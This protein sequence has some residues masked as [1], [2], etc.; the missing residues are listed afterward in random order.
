MFLEF[1]DD[2]LPWPFTKAG[3]EEVALV[4]PEAGGTRII[5][6]NL[7]YPSV[8][9]LCYALRNKDVWPEG[10]TW[11][12]SFPWSCAMGLARAMWPEYIPSPYHPQVTQALGLPVEAAHGVFIYRDSENNEP[13]DIASALEKV[14][15]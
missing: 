3:T 8:A 11:N 13:A 2:K 10:F 5:A 12:F 15:V 4:S 6:P 7:K 14:G 1:E 9:G